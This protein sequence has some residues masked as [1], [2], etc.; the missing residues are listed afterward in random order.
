MPRPVAATDLAR[1]DRWPNC[2]FRAPVGP[3]DR[4]VKQERPDRVEFPPQVPL[5]PLHVGD[6]AGRIQARREAGDQL[7]AHHGEPVRGEAVGPVPVADLAD[8]G[9]ARM[10]LGQLPAPSEEVGQTRLMRG[11]HE[12]PIRGPAVAHEHAPR[13]P[14]RG[15][16]AASAKPRPG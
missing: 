4:G 12:L 3:V 13:S 16:A 2:V 11:A 7:A 1:D 14:P 15:L 9:R 6:T 5:E 8:P 10:I